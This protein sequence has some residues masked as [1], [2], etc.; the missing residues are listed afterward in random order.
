MLRLSGSSSFI[1]KK[2]VLSFSIRSFGVLLIFAAHVVL[3]R[4]MEKSEYGIFSYAYN[5]ILILAIVSQCGYQFSSV[6]FIPEY[7]SEPKLLSGYILSAFKTCVLAGTLV[8]VLALIVG[9][10]LPSDSELLKASL[11]F[12]LII[13]ILVAVN[14]FAQQGLRALKEIFFSQFF[15]QLI[16]PVLLLIISGTFF[17]R[18]SKLSSDSTLWILGFCYMVITAATVLLFLKKSKF[19]TNADLS[20]TSHWWKVSLP[21][22]MWGLLAVLINRADLFVLGIYVKPESLASYSIASRIAGLLVFVP[23][24][25]NSIGEPTVS[26]LY[27]EKKHREL[28]ALMGKILAASMGLGVLLFIFLSLFSERILSAFG[29]TY[30]GNSNTLL[31]LG[32]SQ[33]INLSN[34]ILVSILVVSGGQKKLMTSM[35]ITMV[36]LIVLLLVLIPR[37]GEMGAA[38]SVLVATCL[39]DLQLL[40]LIRKIKLASSIV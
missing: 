5:L 14:S 7:K 23:A 2:A 25:L 27:F 39:F 37:Y 36:A 30:A 4:S 38:F 12:P 35:L 16:L 24:A 13:L 17:L 22:G 26:T 21:L 33:L 20:Q 1:Y 3:A 8:S 19:S 15:E 32:F 6:R 34:S 9:Y 40:Y 11:T 29:K 31:I 28:S 10:I 18:G